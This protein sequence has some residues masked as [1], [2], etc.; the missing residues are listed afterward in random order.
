MTTIAASGL[1]LTLPMSSRYSSAAGVT[2]LVVAVLALMRIE[3]HHPFARIGVANLVTGARGMLT[4]LVAAALIEVP[5]EDLAWVLVALASAA[6]AL[7]GFDGWAARRQGVVSAFGARFDMEVD[8]F[9]IL[10][11]AALVWRFDKA[12]AW[13]LASGLMRYAFVAAGL[14]WPWFDRPLPASRR[15]QLVC[16]VQIASLVAALA[17][18]VAPPL[19]AWVA[20]VS[21]ALLT[22]SFWVDVRWLASG[23]DKKS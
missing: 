2:F 10:A 4:A 12:G 14:V 6:L 17:P 22:W 19:S 5:S 21:L 1:R 7:D 18:V 20:G 8:A 15:R 3:R 11:L 16:V 23:Y 13:V 9:L